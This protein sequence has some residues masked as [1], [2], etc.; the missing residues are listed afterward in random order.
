[1]VFIRATRKCTI[2][3]ILRKLILR[4]IFDLIFSNKVRKCWGYKSLINKSMQKQGLWALSNRKTCFSIC[5]GQKSSNNETAYQKQEQQHLMCGSRLS[6]NTSGFQK[7]TGRNEMKNKSW[8][9]MV[10]VKEKTYILYLLIIDVQIGSKISKKYLQF[11]EVFSY[12]FYWGSN[13]NT[14]GF[15]P[16]MWWYITAYKKMEDICRLWPDSFLCEN[17]NASPFFCYFLHCFF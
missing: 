2:V 10:F 6:K 4:P 7:K 5:K 13:L 12:L 3:R 17:A 14:I 15:L 16:K 11:V 1:M 8:S 9:G